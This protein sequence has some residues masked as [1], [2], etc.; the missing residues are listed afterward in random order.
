MSKA[1]RKSPPVW[2]R[3]GTVNTSPARRGG[4]GAPSLAPRSTSPLVP[5]TRL[6]SKWAAADTV[7]APTPGACAVTP[8][9]PQ[10]LRSSVTTPVVLSTDIACVDSL[11]KV[12]RPGM[13]ALPPALNSATS[14][15]PLLSVADTCTWAVACPATPR[16]AR[17]PPSTLVPCFTTTLS[18]R[19][20]CTSAEA[21]TT[22]ATAAWP[23]NE[24]VMFAVPAALQVTTGPSSTTAGC[25]ASPPGP[26]TRKASLALFEAEDRGWMIPLVSTTATSTTACS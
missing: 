10:W 5:A 6:H 26:D 22:T 21:A 12:T 13:A 16:R 19:A 15:R 8:A 3:S 24:T 4:S 9:V 25:C 14:P 11:A 17:P 20:T 1:P 18:I 2:T 23:A 7:E